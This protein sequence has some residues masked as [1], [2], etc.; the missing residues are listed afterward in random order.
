MAQVSR[1]PALLHRACRVTGVRVAL[2]RD[3][4]GGEQTGKKIP[5]VTSHRLN[6]TATMLPS[7]GGGDKGEYGRLILSDL[8]FCGG[9]AD[10]VSLYSRPGCYTL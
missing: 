10:R 3:C 1:N 9:L 8:R 6:H 2:T 4:G 5:T 7:S